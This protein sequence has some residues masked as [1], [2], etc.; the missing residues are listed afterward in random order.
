MRSS[1][2]VSPRFGSASPVPAEATPPPRPWP[3]SG[4]RATSGGSTRL[5]GARG[6]DAAVRAHSSLLVSRR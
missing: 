3:P 6:I 2:A 5:A 4:P 1:I